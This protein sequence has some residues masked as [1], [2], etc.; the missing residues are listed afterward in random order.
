MAIAKKSYVKNTTNYS[1]AELS[2]KARVAA[3]KVVRQR[4]IARKSK[5]ATDK[6]NS[7]W[8]GNK[9]TKPKK[10]NPLTR[11]NQIGKSTRSA[12][13]NRAIHAKKK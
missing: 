12:A 10:V 7:T 2:R 8:I 9:K 13:Q 4:E 3:E 1:K 6:I 5:A 11:L